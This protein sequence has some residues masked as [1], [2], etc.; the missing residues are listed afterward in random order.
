MSKNTDM[1]KFLNI[2]TPFIFLLAILTACESNDMPIQHADNYAYISFSAKTE[3]TL[4]RT[5]P[6]EAY[7]AA[8][9]PATMGVFGYYSRTSHPNLDGANSIYSNESVSY[10]S[11]TENWT[12]TSRKRW[13]DYLGKATSFHFFAYMPKV[14]GANV[15]EEKSDASSSTS[16]SRTFTLSFPFA[17]STSVEETSSENTSSNPTP[18]PV[19]FDIKKAPIICAKPQ[20]KDSMDAQKT[21]YIFDR[22][23]KF[24][25]DQTLTGYRLLFKLDTKMGAVRQFRIKRVTLSGNLA[26]KGT[27]SRSYTWDVTKKE[28]TQG[29][30]EWKEDDLTYT[31][32]GESTA[33]GGNTVTAPFEI[34][35]K[36]NKDDTNTTSSAFENATKSILLDNSIKDYTQWG[37]AFYTIPDKNFTPTIKV[38]YDVV[39]KDEKQQEVI[40]RKNVT[41]AIELNEKNFESLKNQKQGVTAMI[42]PIRILIQPR[43]LYVLADEDA[44]TGHLLID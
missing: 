5:N 34:P 2:V 21:E 14:D 36:D 10:N 42:Y 37:P 40:T 25:F 24:K 38:T 33:A 6:Y 29:A 32:F 1:K 3:K 28:W 20:S 31:T 30:I 18:S 43:Y 19:I 9:H 11:T 22:V 44:Y 26:T 15:I 23:V 7:D 16:T 4:T 12:A 13:N 27:V 8:K 17:M 35:Y 41:S 39:F